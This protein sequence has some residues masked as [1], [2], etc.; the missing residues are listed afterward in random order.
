MPMVAPLAAGVTA[1]PPKPLSL[2]D[3]NNIYIW[4]VQSTSNNVVWQELWIARDRPFGIVVGQAE[5][6][7]RLE[8]SPDLV[9]WQTVVTTVS[10]GTSQ[11]VYIDAFGDKS[12]FFRLKP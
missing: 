3:T 6:L 8:T 12:R 10:T 1:R 2:I 4:D 9:T 11:V 5:G 7:F